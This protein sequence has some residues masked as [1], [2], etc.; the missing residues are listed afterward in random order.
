MF[1]LGCSLLGGKEEVS[2]PNKMSGF[3]LSNT[4]IKSGLPHGF[5]RLDYLDEEQS[6]EELL[7]ITQAILTEI[8]AEDTYVDQFTDSTG[9]AGWLIFVNAPQREVSKVTTALENLKIESFMQELDERMDTWNFHRR[10]STFRTKR[11]LE[12]A[13]YKHMLENAADTVYIT[14]FVTNVGDRTCTIFD[15]S[16]S[17][18]DFE[19]LLTTLTPDK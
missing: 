18:E 13:K 15:L 1:S 11:H 16:R 8:D 3:Y 17:E 4:Q 14:R 19:S 12:Y 7:E 10:G 2:H 9:T 6:G 5:Q